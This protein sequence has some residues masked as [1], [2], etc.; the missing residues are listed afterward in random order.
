MKDKYII[1]SAILGAGLILGTLWYV[2]TNQKCDEALGVCPVSGEQNIDS[3]V[4]REENG[5]QIIRILAR[6]GYSPRQI[7]AK[8]GMPVRIEME[9]KGTY[10]CSSVFVIPSLKYQKR[11][12]PTGV[13]VIDVPAQKSG[14][15][16]T[17]LCGMGMYSFEIEF[18]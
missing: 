12:P 10:D 3:G 2:K 8:A 11:L 7:S 15:S 16:L 9:T 1:L 18:N 4:T 5:T 14:S 17:G 6:G 13:T